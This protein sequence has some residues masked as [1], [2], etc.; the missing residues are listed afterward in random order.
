MTV[1]LGLEPILFMIYS[2][3]FAI[4]VYLPGLL[5][6]KVSYQGSQVVRCHPTADEHLDTF[7]ALERENSLS[8]DFWIES[9]I[10]G[11]PIDIMV[12]LEHV[13]ALGK[14]PYILHHYNGF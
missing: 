9:R 11:S 5:G 13:P 6:E 2:F 7:K 14:L 10:V 8:L 12:P 4:V 3:I 1:A